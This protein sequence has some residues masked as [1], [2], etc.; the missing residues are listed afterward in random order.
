MISA[1]ESSSL[2][3]LWSSNGKVLEDGLDAR[4]V[5]TD[6][7]LPQ[8][9]GRGTCPRVEDKLGPGG[10][11]ISSEIYPDKTVVDLIIRKMGSCLV[12]TTRALTNNIDVGV[13]LVA[14]QNPV[15]RTPQV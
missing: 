12:R 11:I 3:S 8:N 15:R 7:S 4:L 5:N 9:G 10:I 14:K 1:S 13:I 6:L 2:L